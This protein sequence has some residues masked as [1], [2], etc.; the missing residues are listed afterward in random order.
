MSDNTK[1]ELKVKLLNLRILNQLSRMVVTASC[2]GPS[3]TASGTG[4]VHNVDQ[5][6][7]KE[8]YVKIIPLYLHST[9]RWIKLGHNWVFQQ[10]NYSKHALKLVLECI[11][12]G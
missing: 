1:L 6:M 8:D 2:C 5:A 7:K 12:A 3:F 4:T 10:G 11:K 9:A